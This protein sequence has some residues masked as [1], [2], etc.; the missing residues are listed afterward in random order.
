MPCITY[1]SFVSSSRIASKKLLVDFKFALKV[2]R[3]SWQ[4]LI[5]FYVSEIL[6]NYWKILVIDRN[7]D[8]VQFLIL[9]VS[10]RPKVNLA[11]KNTFRFNLRFSWQAVQ[12]CLPRWCMGMMRWYLNSPNADCFTQNYDHL[13]IFALLYQVHRSSQNKMVTFRHFFLRSGL[14]NEWNN[15][16]FSSI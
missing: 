8:L 3:L 11:N 16:W 12:K 5:I 6:K 2:F 1:S 7:R 15:Y 9:S 10:Y 4:V 13:R 14:I